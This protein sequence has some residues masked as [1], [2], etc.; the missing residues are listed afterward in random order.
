[1]S[2]T[3]LGLWAVYKGFLKLIG[4]L[5]PQNLLGSV[6]LGKIQQIFLNLETGFLI[7]FYLI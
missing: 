2:H 6:G 3:D 7:A 5:E 1:V 4:F